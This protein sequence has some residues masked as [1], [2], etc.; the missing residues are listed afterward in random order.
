MRRNLSSFS[1]RSI[2]NKLNRIHLPINPQHSR[3]FPQPR[4]FWLSEYTCQRRYIKIHPDG[5]I[6][7]GLSRFVSFL[8]DFS[9][10]RSNVAHMYSLIGFAYDRAS[11]F[12]I[13][14][15]RYLEKYPSMKTFLDVVHD[16]VKGKHY[17]TYA[18]ISDRFI[19][20]EAA[21]TNFRDRLGESLYNGI[22]HA[23]VLVAPSPLFRTSTYPCLGHS[24]INSEPFETK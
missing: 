11:L 3:P 12:L 18:G 7:G 20:C 10:V 19:P 1:L 15:I 21:F 16:P 23:L 13:K 9:F 22:F 4:D 5:R 24:T 6:V 8:I 17:R 14:L 2:I